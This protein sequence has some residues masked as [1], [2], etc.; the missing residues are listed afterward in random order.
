M[1]RL[2][3]NA[4]DFGL[5]AGV[6]RGILAAHRRGVVTSTT[7]LVT[8]AIDRDLVAEAR[9]SGIGLGIHVNFTLGKP[10]SR[11]RSLVGADGRFV[12]DPRR[13]AAA[14]TARDAGREVDAQVERFLVLV[15]RPP[16]HLDSHHH[17]ALYSPVREAFLAAAARLGVPVRSEHESARAGARAHRLRTTDHFFGGSGPDAYWAPART[18]AHLRALPDG[19]SEFMTHPGYFD[20]DLGYSRYGRQRETELIG[21]GSPDAR[22]AAAALGISL[23]TFDTLSRDGCTT[24]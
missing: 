2:I 21:L 14:A 16:T 5:T 15:K 13:S 12:R 1:R 19:V 23:C 18:L 3:V 20:A 24:L 22:A 11:G 10:V 7:M 9:D 6:S 8:G 17:V 4:D